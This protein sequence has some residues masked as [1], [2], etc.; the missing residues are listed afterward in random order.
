MIG[1]LKAAP[2]LSGVTG[3]FIEVGS[4]SYIY[5][6]SAVT[7]IEPVCLAHYCCQPHLLF[8]MCSVKNNTNDTNNE[9]NR[10]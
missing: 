10:G 2:R 9:H 5:V 3:F 8:D 6:C 1:I 7:I 4:L